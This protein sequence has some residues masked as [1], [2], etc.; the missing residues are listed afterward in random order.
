MK[1]AEAVKPPHK[2]RVYLIDDHEIFRAGLRNL[3]TASDQFEI[4]GESGYAETFTGHP[5]MFR[6]DIAL[7]GQPDL[8]DPMIITLKRLKEKLPR[9]KIVLLIHRDMPLEELRLVSD[10]TD[11]IIDR[12]CSGDFL[13][14]AVTAIGLGGRVYQS[15][16]PFSCA[17]SGLDQSKASPAT[18]QALP[19]LTTREL[20]LVPLVA[21]GKPNKAIA[22]EFGVAEVTV[23]K[24]LQRLY[25]KLGVANRTQAAIKI[26]QLGLYTAGPGDN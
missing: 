20:A 7:L 13:L 4:V 24:A 12:E 6:A 11:G 8:V 25:A 26:S 17:E 2:K 15:C 3:L 14:A 10:F 5:G 22:S 23:K 18:V 21:T 1:H 16:P 19:H 9:I